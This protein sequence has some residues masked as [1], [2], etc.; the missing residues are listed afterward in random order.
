MPKYCLTLDL[1]N[2]PNLIQEYEEHHRN[3]WPEIV[4]SIKSSGIINMEIYRFDT[5]LFMIME[6]DEHFSFKKKS[7]MDA[8]SPRVLAWE[9]L[10][11]KYQQPLKGSLIT[12]K[13]KLMDK[14]FTLS[15]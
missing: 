13:W 10:M 3:I 2:D 14:I 15:S 4:E 1:I 12:E 5:R 11:L 6:T 7:A 8:A 9:T